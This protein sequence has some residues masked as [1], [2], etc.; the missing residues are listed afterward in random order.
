[1]KELTDI[2]SLLAKHHVDF[3]VVGGYAVAAYGSALVTQD[4]DICCDFSAD[5]LMRLQ[6]ALES[7]NPVHRMTAKR[8]PLV[9][10]PEKCKGL[11]NLYLD[12]D[13][14]QLDCLGSV[15]GIGNFEAVK[16]RSIVVDIDDFQCR[17]I[18]L[19][20]LIE[21]KKAMG[22]PRDLAAVQELEAIREKLLNN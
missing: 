11:K 14:G 21:A 3:V 16:R 17:L 12:T 19:A 9:L 22:R 18:D 6:Q 7:N 4:I 15:L 20:A 10:T 5:N 8:L 1:M 13:N 2:L